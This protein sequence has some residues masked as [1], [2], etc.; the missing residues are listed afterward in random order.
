MVMGGGGTTVENNVTWSYELAL[1]PGARGQVTIGAAHVRVGGHE[2]ASNAVPV[3][4]GAAAAAPP[5]QRPQRQPNLFPRGLFGDEP[6]EQQPL[7]SSSRRRSSAPSPTSAA[8]SW[9]S[10]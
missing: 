10:R 5:P 7:S 9:A 4:V 6:D 2:L 1:P 3:R 8:R